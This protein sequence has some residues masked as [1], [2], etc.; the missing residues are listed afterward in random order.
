MQTLKG[1]ICFYFVGES[2]AQA[3]GEPVED[4]GVSEVGFSTSQ[5][6]VVMVIVRVCA[7]EMP[8]LEAIRDA[9]GATI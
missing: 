3:R 8:K 9:C 5:V 1:K 4:G 2:K 7:I 6:N